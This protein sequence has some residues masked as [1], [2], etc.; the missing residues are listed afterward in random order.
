MRRFLALLPI[1]CSMVVISIASSMPSAQPPDLGFAW[2]DKVWHAAVFFIVGCVAYLAARHGLLMQ[3]MWAVWTLILWT[4]LFAAVDEWH[5]TFVPGR[6]G[7]VAD[8]MADTV[9]ALAAASFFVLRR[10]RTA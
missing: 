3:E 4:C 8:W 1:C 5:Q 6:T 2:S 9:G 7:D 10:R